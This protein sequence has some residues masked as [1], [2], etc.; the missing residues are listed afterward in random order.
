MSTELVPCG[1]LGRPQLWAKAQEVKSGAPQYNNVIELKQLPQTPV[2]WVPDWRSSE[3]LK[4]Q[5][6]LHNSC[7][8]KNAAGFQSYT[9]PLPE[10]RVLHVT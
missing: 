9:A 7:I 6:P 2:P 1:P 4:D 10:D 8:T 3:L 5:V